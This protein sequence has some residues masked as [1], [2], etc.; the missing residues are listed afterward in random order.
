MTRT[1]L[2]VLFCASLAINVGAFGAATFRFHGDREMASASPTQHGAGP[3]QLQ[4]ALGLT[5]E[6]QAAFELARDEASGQISEASAQLRARRQEL[7]DLL[8]GPSPD[9]AVI[10]RTL[11]EISAEQL[12]IQRAVVEQWVKQ[13]D[14]L[15]ETQHGE[16]VRLLGERLVRDGHEDAE[17]GEEL[18]REGQ[19]EDGEDED[20]KD[21]EHR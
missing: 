8:I 11:V 12:T 1:I 7:F 17:M 2:L 21:A 16:F 20:H 13:Q 6:Q 19:H 9:R 3:Q 10:D 15:S 18:H 4:T 14:V 5:N